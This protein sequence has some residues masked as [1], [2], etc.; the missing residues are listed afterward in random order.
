MDDMYEIPISIRSS[1]GKEYKIRNRGDYRTILDCFQALDDAE[2][3]SSERLMASLLIF[4]EDFNSVGDIARLDNVEELTMKMYDF[5]NCGQKSEGNHSQHKLIDWEN[6]AQLIC[7][8]IN[9]V[10]GYEVR[11]IEYL[12]WWTFM[13]YYSA[14]GE[15]PIST[16]VSIRDK[17]VRGKRLEKYER[18]YRNNNPQ[19]FVWK[20]KTVADIEAEEYV[21]QLWN[22]GG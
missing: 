7:S 18:E 20:S 13:G 11:A 15:S 3:E 10:A 9:K 22:S 16:V 1:D 4:Y 8:A 6:D 2:L 17:I 14:I 5:F 12:H 21:N 19:Y